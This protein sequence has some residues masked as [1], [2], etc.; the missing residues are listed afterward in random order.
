MEES[1][2]MIIDDLDPKAVAAKM[3]RLAVEIQ[4]R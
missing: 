4:N 2:R 3:Q 1:Q